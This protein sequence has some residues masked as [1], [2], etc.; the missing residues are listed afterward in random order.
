MIASFFR[1]LDEHQG[2]WLL[3]SGQATILYGAA[4]FSEDVDLW[5]EPSAANLRRL[6]A[7]LRASAASYYKLTPPLTAE[8][9]ARHHGFHF[10][11]PEEDGTVMYLDVMGCPPRVGSFAR[12]HERAR[13]FETQWGALR[14]LAIPELVELKKTQRPRDYPIIGRLVLSA[15]RDQRAS[16][17]DEDLRWA[18]ANVF[19][20]DE[21]RQLVTEYP[22]VCRVLGAAPVLG[23]AAE[24]ISQGRQLSEALED[25]LEELFDSRAAQLRKADRHFWRPVIDELGELRA[26]GRLMQQ[27]AR[28]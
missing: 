3:V 18:A 12:A 27:G 15:L 14:T 6:A 23:Q 24:Q 26:Q 21:F 22:D 4:T 8:M 28:V 13:T 11:I 20:L 17:A 7:A 1:H 19:G 2:E 25:A 9:A 10:T 16:V 5:V